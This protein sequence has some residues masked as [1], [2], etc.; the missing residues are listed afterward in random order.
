MLGEGRLVILSGPSG[1]GKDTVIEAWCAADPRV[2]RVVAATTRAP[3][4]GEADG[5]DYHFMD[6]DSFL[7]MAE[8][9]AF[10]EFKEVHGNHYATPLRQL[11]GLLDAGKVAVLKID[12]QGAA[13][14]TPKRPDAVTIFLLPPSDEEL[15]RR[16]RGRGTE[17]EATVALRL[18]AAHDEVVRSAAYA[19]RLVNDDLPGLVARL[20]EIVP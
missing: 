10:L 19:H 8:D 13:E 12:V 2:T 9:G 17:D 7:R 4:P 5:V 1:V 6:V 20:R 3:R 18:R 11:E 15:E 14:V 16:I